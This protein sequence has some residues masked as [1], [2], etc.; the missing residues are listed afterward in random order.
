MK[1]IILFYGWFG[2]VKAVSAAV[3]VEHHACMIFNNGHSRSPKDYLE[4]KMK[5]F[6]GGAW[7][8]LEARSVKKDGALVCVGYI[9]KKEECTS[10]HNE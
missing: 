2:S 5:Y 7:I 10:I 1:K 3:Q 8:A 4:G 9:Y 6:L